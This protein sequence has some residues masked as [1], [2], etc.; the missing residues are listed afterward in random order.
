M[1]EQNNYIP[2]HWDTDLNL[3]FF[4]GVSKY[5]SINRAYKHGHVTSLGFMIPKQRNKSRSLAYVKA[6]NKANEYL[7][8]I[9]KE[10][11][12]GESDS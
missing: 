3:M 7:N 12:L 5:K 2:N 6:R 8:L 10:Y 4:S 11:G 9:K 1:E